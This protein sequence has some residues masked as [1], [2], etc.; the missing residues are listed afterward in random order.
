MAVGYQSFYQAQLTS[1]ITDTD[2]TIPVD[3]APTPSEGFL[4]IE[5]TVAN[6]REIIVTESNR[7]PPDFSLSKKALNV[8]V[9]LIFCFLFIRLCLL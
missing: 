8:F 5:S 1:N 7:S 4:V 3:V 6:K 2:L 9:N